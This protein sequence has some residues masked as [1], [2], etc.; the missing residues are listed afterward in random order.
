[1]RNFHLIFEV[2]EVSDVFHYVVN[3]ALKF[4]CDWYMHCCFQLLRWHAFFGFSFFTYS[5]PFFVCIG[6]FC[7]DLLSGLLFGPCPGCPGPHWVG[8]PVFSISIGKL[9]ELAQ[10]L[11]HTPLNKC[12]W[13]KSIQTSPKYSKSPLPKIMRSWQWSRAPCRNLESWISTLKSRN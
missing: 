11:N 4:T 12:K 6:V 13:W 7:T 10:C 9:L 1:M 5:I 3:L 2:S 8:P